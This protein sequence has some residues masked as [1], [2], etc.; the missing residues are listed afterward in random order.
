MKSWA[1]REALIVGCGPTVEEEA[2]FARKHMP[3]ALVIGANYGAAVIKPDI[4]FSNHARLLRDIAKR[5]EEFCGWTGELHT[6]PLRRDRNFTEGMTC[7]PDAYRT[8]VGSGMCAAVATR[9]MG[10]SRAVLAGCP[11]S[12]RYWSGRKAAALKE[13]ENH[14]EW[15]PHR[16]HPGYVQAIKDV[17]GELKGFATSTSGTTRMLL[18]QPEFMTGMEAWLPQNERNTNEYGETS[19]T[20]SALGESA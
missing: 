10:C 18:G 12:L 9:L 11:F 8:Y 20:A 19:D 5:I 15:M 7:W 1:G 14:V 6:T 3:D 2:A 13:H 16:H 17:C 4:I